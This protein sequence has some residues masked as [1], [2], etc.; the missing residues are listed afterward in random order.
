MIIF[1]KAPVAGTVKTRLI[2]DS[3]FVA[4]DA[5]LL[6]EA[7]LK[8][9]IAL[10]AESNASEIVIGFT[11]ADER[12]SME[13]I[14]KEVV[15]ERHLERPIT[16]LIQSGTSFDE[17]FGSVVS[18]AFAMGSENLVILGGDL[19][20]LP[21]DIINRAFSFLTEDRRNNSVV[22]GPAG[23]GGIYLVGITRHFDPE[24]F[25]RNQLFSGGVEISQFIK[26]CKNE[27]KVLKLLPAFTDIDIE[28]DLVS[29]MLY[30]DAMKIA[31]K[32]VGFHF[33][34]YTADAITQ[35]RSIVLEHRGE[36]R[37]RRI[38]TMRA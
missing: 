30:I 14:V 19:P 21:P 12:E 24:Y 1:S 16:F 33:P 17:R 10:S 20:Y 26:L 11:P 18:A 35:L 38:G 5:A 25:S 28:R 32:F 6:A 23:E 34:N 15:K 2:Q 29:L 8:D 22:L 4:K 27:G 3:C 13:R 7:M 36:T 37:H 31:K 9:T